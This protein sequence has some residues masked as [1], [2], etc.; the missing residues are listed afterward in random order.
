MSGI[1]S[2][3]FRQRIEE[4]GRGVFKGEITEFS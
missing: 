4:I 2:K 1:F 3:Y